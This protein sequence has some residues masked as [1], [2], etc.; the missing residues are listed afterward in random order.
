LD[1]H[2]EI[3]CRAIYLGLDLWNGKFDGFVNFE[4]I[5]ASKEHTFVVD[6]GEILIDYLKGS[7]EEL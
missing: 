3:L 1:V 7:G 6:L 5:L 2:L 4:L